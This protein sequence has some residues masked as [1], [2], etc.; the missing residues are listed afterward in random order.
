MDYLGAGFQVAMEDLRLRGAGNI[1]GEV[2]S[3]H[4]GRVGLDLYLEM[5]EQAVNKIKNGGVPLQIETELNLGLTAHIPED[6]ITDGRERLGWYKRLSAAPDAA[7]RQE[8]ELELRDRFG[9]LPEPLEVFMAVLALKQF[10]T[11]AQ[12]V[13]ADVNEDRL[14]ITWNEK[15][16]AI[17]PEKLVPFLAAQGGR[18]KL[19]PPSGLELKLDMALATAARLDAAR[20]ALGNLLAG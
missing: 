4:M 17:A 16:T 5:L 12:A 7:A 19:I 11:G 1:L 18:V 9:S 6:Y 3:G 8:L 15:Q 13:K 10:L 2:Q 20:L 14:R